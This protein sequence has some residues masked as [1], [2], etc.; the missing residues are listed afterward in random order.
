M[1]NTLLVCS[2]GGHLKQL[3]TLAERIG[4]SPAQQTWVTFE[5]DFSRSL[6][7]DREVVYAPFAGPRDAKNIVRMRMMVGKVIGRGKF[8]RAISTGSSPAVAFL[9]TA[10][11]RGVASHY[12]ESAARATGPSVSGRILSRNRRVHTYTQYPVWSNTRWQYRGSIFDE[13]APGSIRSVSNPRRA[14]VSVGTQEGYGFDRL[15]RAIVPLLAGF[16]EVMWQS[17]PQDVSGYGIEGRHGVPH[18]ELKAAVAESDVVIAHAGTGAA[19]TA[20]DAGKTPILVPRLARYDEHV[21]DHQVQIAYEL[22]RRGLALMRHPEQLGSDDLVLAASR[23]VSKVIAS[24]FA[25]DD[26]EVATTR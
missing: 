2:G 3:F 9:P 8:E 14:V 12:I 25:L 16:D 4:I 10:A 19:L 13:Y 7:A 17:G 15:F 6:L 23:S 24:P 20:I 11:R 5:N 22:D 18:H 21:D 26:S 1:S